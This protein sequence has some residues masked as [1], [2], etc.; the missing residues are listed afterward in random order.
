MTMQ[1]QP[2]ANNVR[3]IT[4]ISAGLIITS[5]TLWLTGC[6]SAGYQK[7]DSAAVSIQT[8]SA[9][10]QGESRALELTMGALRDLVN[11]S[12]AD[13][14][15]EFKH[16]S[17]ALDQLNTAAKRSAATGKRMEQRHAAYLQAWDKELA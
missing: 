5:A 15:L 7:G 11:E 1:N 13:L 8:A 12:P 6:S 4:R 16:F 10:V 2:K 17:S 3:S 14:K 9:D